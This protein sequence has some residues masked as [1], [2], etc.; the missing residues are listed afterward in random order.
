MLFKTSFTFFLLSFV[1]AGSIKAPRA[2]YPFN[3]LVAY[4][5]ELSDNGNG[6]FAHGITGDPADVYGFGTWTNGPVAVSYLAD[7]LKVPMTDYA[8]GGCCGG[9]SFGATFDNAYT[10]SPAG[11]TDMLGQIS[12]Y[13]GTGSKG[14]ASSLQFL[15][16]GENDLSMHT[17][18]FWLGDAKN[19]QFATDAAAKITASVKSLLN[20]GAPYVMVANIYPKHL[21]P[22]TPKYLCGTNADCVKTW[23]QVITTANAA[24]Q[25]SLGQFGKK[26]IYYDVF[27]YMVQILNNPKAYGFPK[28]LNLFCDGDETAQW[29]D[30]MVKGNANQYFWMNFIQPT[31]AGHK[32]IAQDMKKTIDAHFA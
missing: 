28:S 9:G 31:T 4:G 7:L 24:I 10:K 32:L 26:V 20:K 2:A 22:V 15:W 19:A 1:A 30:C 14:I 5:D 16:F 11:A 27:S 13:T 6:S 25:K 3:N 18:A 23:G 21:A 12:N 29:D 17:D 8:F